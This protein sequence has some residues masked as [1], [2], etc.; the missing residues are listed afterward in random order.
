MFY[1]NH[2]DA[3]VANL[4]VENGHRNAP[5]SPYGGNV[6]IGDAGGAVSNC[7]L[8]G[9]T[10]IGNY[11]RGTGAWL[12]SENALLTHCIITNNSAIG[13]G[14]QYSGNYGGIFVHIE[15][16]TVANC[17]IANNRDT[18]GSGLG[19]QDKQSWS[20]G[21]TVRDGGCIL[22]CTV[23]TNEARYTGGIYLYSNA[24]ATNVVVAGCVNKCSYT[25]SLG[26][27]GWTDIGFKGALDNA[28]HCASDGGEE[29]DSTCIAGTA[30]EFFLDMAGRDYRPAKNSPLINKGVAYEG[31][32]SFDLLGKKRVQ[33][34]APDIGAY[35]TA[36]RH[37]TVC[38]R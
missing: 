28:S 6:S 8:R 25:N 33:G 37:M 38:I 20:C 5:S 34:R 21:V 32:A 15:K 7:V 19:G 29:L 2:P 30:A 9:A 4:T 16:G 23:V 35:E 10:S 3:R 18:G 36:P 27:I 17:L 12:N 22:N 13:S 31:I 24:Y 11:A 1:L 14:Y 26:E